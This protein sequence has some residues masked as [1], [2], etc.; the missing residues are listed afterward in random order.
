V[1]CALCECC[2]T[3]LSLS[4]PRS[5]FK[6]IVTVKAGQGNELMNAKEGGREGTPK[7]KRGMDNNSGS[8]VATCARRK[9]ARPKLF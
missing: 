9:G 3:L 7:Y 6:K 5:A 8:A 2:G 1:F 4:P